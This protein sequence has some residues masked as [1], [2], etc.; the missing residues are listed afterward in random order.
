MPRYDVDK[1][2]EE[3]GI[4][5]GKTV[6]LA[7]VAKSIP[8]IS[9]L[10]WEVFACE[11]KKRGFTVFTNVSG[12]ERP[13]FGTDPLD[14]T[15]AEITSILDYAGYFVGLRSG[16]CDVISSSDCRKMILFP[17]DPDQAIPF[18]SYYGMGQI[19]G[20]RN[21]KEAEIATIPEK[22]EIMRIIN[23]TIKYF[24]VCEPD[25]KPSAIL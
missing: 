16:I 1:R 4:V 24:K 21:F 23:A 6:V 7:P 8:Q 22:G 10:F 2:C 9:L 15:I 20:A 3:L 13:I 12:K 11:L 14:C 17:K 18:K 5:K 19:I 25:E